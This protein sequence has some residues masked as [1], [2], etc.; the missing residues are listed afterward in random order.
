MDEKRK[1]PVKCFEY[2]SI[3]FDCK[4][5]SAAFI[6]KN[7]NI[8]MISV[9]RMMLASLDGH[10]FISD[11]W[12]LFIEMRFLLT[13]KMIQVMITDIAKNSNMLIK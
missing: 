12:S 8:N 13:R 2:G 7:N 11:D 6:F 3:P 1:V 4:K 5:V 10:P 9:T